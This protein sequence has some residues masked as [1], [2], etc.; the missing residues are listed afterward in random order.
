MGKLLDVYY[1]KRAGQEVAEAHTLG[2]ELVAVPPHEEFEVDHN[3]H[4]GELFIRKT[5]VPGVLYCVERAIV[6]DSSQTPEDALQLALAA[7]AK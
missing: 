5:R 2:I 1:K 4:T 3:G 7:A 6:R